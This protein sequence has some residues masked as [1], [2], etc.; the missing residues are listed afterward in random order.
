[1]QKQQFVIYVILRLSD[2]RIILLCL[3]EENM[4]N[5]LSKNDWNP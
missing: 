5:T 1:M 3:W 4:K 2:K